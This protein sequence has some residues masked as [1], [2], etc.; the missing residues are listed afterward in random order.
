MPILEVRCGEGFA[1]W[2]WPVAIRGET[3]SRVTQ[4]LRKPPQDRGRSPTAC[5]DEGTS[6]KGRLPGPVNPPSEMGPGQTC[7]NPFGSLWGWAEMRADATEAGSL[8]VVERAAR[9]SANPHRIYN[10]PRAKL[11]PGAVLVTEESMASCEDC[12]RRMSAVLDAS[13]VR[14]NLSAVLEAAHQD[15]EISSGIQ[16]YVDKALV[17]LEEAIRALNDHERTHR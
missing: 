5:S 4:V 8:A 9:P 3:P 1:S 11:L 12:E 6:F 13:R 16:Y 7:R 15:A 14:H 10:P 17:D 2:S